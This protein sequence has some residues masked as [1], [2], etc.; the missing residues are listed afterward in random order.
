MLARFVE[1]E[2]RVEHSTRKEIY[3]RLNH[4]EIELWLSELFYGHHT[5]EAVQIDTQHSR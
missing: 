2:K 5:H 1:A 4:N 3:Q